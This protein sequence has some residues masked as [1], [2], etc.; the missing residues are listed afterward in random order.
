MAE[1]TVAK[2]AEDIHI[3][4]DK[5]LQ[6][7][8][9]AGIP[10]SDESAPV[11]E[12]IKRKLLGHLQKSH[13]AKS[14]KKITLKRKSVSKLSLGS[15]SRRGKTVNVEIRKKKTYIKRSA[16]EEAEE[17]K[18]QAE[19]A[20]RLQAEEA[21]R[22]EE[23]AKRLAEEEAKRAEDAKREAEEAA[24]R[25]AEEARLQEESAK[26][27]A[28][29]VNTPEEKSKEQKTQEDKPKEQSS[30]EPD[31]KPVHETTT[32]RKDDKDAM[33]SK[34]SAKKKAKKQMRS[35]KARKED[36]D[37]LKQ[38]TFVKPTA[39]IIHKVSLPETIT[40][41]DLA[42][43][44]SVKAAEVI[45]IMMTM[46]VMATI[47]QV[48]DQDTAILIV[49]EMGHEALPLKE[50][51]LEESLDEAVVDQG[52]AVTRAPVVTIM[53]HVDHG[54]TSLLDYIRT[55]KVAA[56][57]A[58]GITQHIGAYDVH[59]AKG[60]ITFLD[61]PGHAAF[62]AM[63]AR[64]AQVTD[65]VILIVAA[66]DGVKPQ[67]AEAIQHA[68]AAK[69]PII[70]AINKI[71]KPE[72]DP[73]R[74]K[75]E[76]TQYEVIP[77][78]WG[79]ETM[80][81]PISAKTGEGVDAL[82]DAISLQAEVLELKAVDTGPAK[83]AVIE[84]RLDKGRGPVAT[85]LIQKGQLNKGDIVLAGLQY[86]RVR[87]ILDAAGHNLK[88]A[89]PS[90]PVQILGLSGVPSAGDEAQV[91]ADER[92]A[93]EVALFRQGKYRDVKLARKQQSSLE[94][95]FE[96]AARG[97]IQTL[98]IVLKADVQGSVEAIADALTKLST[99]EVKVDIV[100][101]GV[102]GINE[103]DV[104]LA[105]ASNAI[106][107]GFNVRADSSARRLVEQEGIDLRYYSVIYDLV[108]QVKNAMTGML[109][110][111]FKEEIVG[112]A[113]VRD[114]FRSPKLGAIAGCMVVEGTVKRNNPIRVLR[115]NVVIYEGSLESLRRFKDDVLEV[116]QGME[117]GIGV[118]NYND[119]KVGDSIEVF[120][121]VE[122][123]REL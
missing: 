95:L 20:A 71:D 63:R 47:N 67:T 58:G 52:E 1:V 23:E 113:E 31:E 27:A 74:V 85:I 79:G 61:T 3:P 50:N 62:T 116:R 12:E 97:D 101:S 41:A 39:P 7:F 11:S 98:R 16:L 121:T 65:I 44:M 35:G 49:E 68:K 32:R 33:V 110:P 103:S 123:K 51:A 10:I 36:L 96:N 76:L 6:Q 38:H 120:E 13:G 40:V 9:E 88:H 54:K 118:K 70:V 100:A 92:K 45:K 114:V 91:V 102:G 46:G 87:G 73:D 81:L 18:R 105:M 109:A 29:V 111:E 82:L 108:D 83:G 112:I 86:G 8:K 48:I 117:C 21:K 94:G 69:V 104:N 25:Q 24:K 26:Q 17:A 15:D 89:G 34:K 115:E 53:G 93:R 84:S 5:L 78:E 107:V 122:V 42:K 19:E 57:E 90:M 66:D 60:A 30:D 106:M 14:E 59:T 28:A 43:K 2:L 4:V 56:A 22:L 72:A 77:E 75:N 64:G 37:L 55:A 119:V 99:E 80:F